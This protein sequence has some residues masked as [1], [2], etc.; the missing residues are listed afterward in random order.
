[1]E[2]E[3]KTRTKRTT[4]VTTLLLLAAQIVMLTLK[5]SGSADY[6][7]AVT[8]I[9]MMIIVGIFVIVLIF[10]ADNFGERSLSIDSPVPAEKGIVKDIVKLLNS[11][12]E[13]D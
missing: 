8:F 1:M 9:P 7:W 10:L 4:S 12:L 6:S 5:L 13:H 11:Y 2:E 3:M